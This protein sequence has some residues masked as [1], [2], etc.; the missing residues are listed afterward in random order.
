MKSTRSKPNGK[1]RPAPNEPSNQAAQALAAAFG[2]YDGAI[3]LDSSDDALIGRF[4]KL[5][6]NARG[7]CGFGARKGHQ[8][9]ETVTLSI[10]PRDELR[11]SLR[12]VWVW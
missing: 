10:C 2:E 12:G 11:G 7:Y 4:V 3:C 9:G 6:L 5:V 8:S 1:T